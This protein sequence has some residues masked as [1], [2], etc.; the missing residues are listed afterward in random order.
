MILA[1]GAIGVVVGFIGG[2][3]AD[4]AG[5]LIKWAVIGGGGYVAAKHFKV[6]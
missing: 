2:K 6:I 4:G 1:A 3:G 5:N